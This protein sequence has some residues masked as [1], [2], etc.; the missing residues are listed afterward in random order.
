MTLLGSLSPAFRRQCEAVSTEQRLLLGLRA[1]DPLPA[2]ALAA[3]LNALVLTPDQLPSLSPDQKAHLGRDDQ[4]SAAVLS[5]HPLWIVFNPRHAPARREADLM[6][7]LS[8]VL[9]DHVMAG[10]DMQTGLPQREQAQEDEATFLGGCLQIP[11]RGLLWA[12]QRGWTT[13]R[14]ATHFGA[15]EAM[16]SFRR[17]MTGVKTKQH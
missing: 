5:R 14:I 13:A 10:F 7:E 6:H 1:F 11:A 9:L 16:V 4:W 12:A 8:H 17:N 3:S 2:D 15:S